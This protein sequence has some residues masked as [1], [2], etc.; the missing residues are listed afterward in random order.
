MPLLPY[1]SLAH[2][3]FSKAAAGTLTEH[4]IK[5]YANPHNQAV[6]SKLKKHS[7]SRR[8]TIAAEGLRMLRDEPFLVIPVVSAS[9][10][11]QLLEMVAE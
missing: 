9:R 2:G 6:L 11:E 10:K 8:T 3:Y 1:S 4:L 5:R 7:A